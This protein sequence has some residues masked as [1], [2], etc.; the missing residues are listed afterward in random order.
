MRTDDGSSEEVSLKEFVFRV[1]ESP[2]LLVSLAWEGKPR[3][4]LIQVYIRQ[5]N[6]RY[7]S[8]TNESFSS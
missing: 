8:D 1:R 5:Y 3:D 2:L 4:E 6:K 7:F